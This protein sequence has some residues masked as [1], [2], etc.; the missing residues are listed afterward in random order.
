MELTFSI[1]QHPK[2]RWRAFRALFRWVR[3]FLLKDPSIA[4]KPG[5]FTVEIYTKK[6]EFVRGFPAESPAG[7][8][9]LRARLQK[10]CSA[11]GVHAFL[12]QHNAPTHFVR[13]AVQSS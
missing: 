1:D 6:G 8:E 4:A 11:V 3:G 10:E 5:P 9:D 13:R 12:L 7:A 2:Y